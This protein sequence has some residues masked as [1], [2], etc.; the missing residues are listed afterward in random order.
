MN[1]YGVVEREKPEHSDNIRS[2]CQF[3]QYKS[4][5]DRP[6]IEQDHSEN[7]RLQCQFAQYK[8]HMH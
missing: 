3:V 4:N 5:T 7:I 2:Q 1:A 6:R 8:S